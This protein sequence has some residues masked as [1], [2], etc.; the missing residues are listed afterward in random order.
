MAAVKKMLY[1]Q[2]TEFFAYQAA[3]TLSRGIFTA[4]LKTANY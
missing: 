4:G 1:Q 3:E 2:L